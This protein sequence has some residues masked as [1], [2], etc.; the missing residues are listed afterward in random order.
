MDLKTTVNLT[1]VIDRSPLSGFQIGV[2]VLCTVCLLMDGFDVQAM[3]YTA[4]A[5]ALS[6]N[7]KAAALG[8]VLSS[9]LVGVLLGSLGFSFLADR[10]GRRPVLILASLVFAGF[11]LVT[12]MVG[13][14][15]QLVLLRFFAGL[16]PGG[17]MPNVVALV[18]E[19]SPAKLRAALIMN[20]ANGLTIGG[21]LGGLLAAWLIPTFGWRSVFLFGGMVPLMIA[22]LMVVAL[23]ESLPF[24]VT[25]GRS[26]EEGARWLQRID[27]NLP[28]GPHVHYVLGSAQKPEG[29][30]FLDLFL[31]GRSAGTLL[32]WL[33]NFMNLLN[34]YFLSSWIPT[35]VTGMGYP[36]RQAVLVATALQAGGVLG[37]MLL[38]S[39]V[40]RLG[41]IPTLAA[42]FTVGCLSVAL[43]GQP[44]W[45]L[46]V[47]G[48]FVFFAGLGILGGQAGINALASSF[49]PTG[50]RAT[51]VGAGLGVGRLGAI[52]GPLIGGEL[53]KLHWPS[54]RLFFF[55]AIP[56]FISLAA[57]ISLYWVIP[58]AASE[59]PEP[60]IARATAAKP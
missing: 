35:L 14:V 18:S 32:L 10:I 29:A 39:F 59:A 40:P 34:L 9:A 7:V 47:L 60:A 36:I 38:G 11:S 27:P 42:C 26:I 5:A 28:T 8:P 54:S 37:A 53:L 25:R 15:N 19:Y 48:F 20:V 13:S 50:L 21:A 4:P 44:G 23:P 33:T 57:M 22:G 1:D 58:P 12:S 31:E 2:F 45:P 17:I 30:T 55:A 6:L 52:A 46:P 3:S 16:G 43:M 51:G 49:Y 41:F 24:L 56:A